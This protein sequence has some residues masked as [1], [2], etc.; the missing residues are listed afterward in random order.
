MAKFGAW[1]QKREFWYQL[2]RG[3]ATYTD[4]DLLFYYNNI[5]PVLR[6]ICAKWRISDPF[7]PEW[8][9]DES[10][11]YE[12]APRRRVSLPTGYTSEQAAALWDSAPVE[13]VCGSRRGTFTERFK[14]KREL[15][16]KTPRKKSAPQDPRLLPLRID[17]TRPQRELIQLVLESVRRHRETLLWERSNCLTKKRTRRRLD[18]YEAYLSTWDLRQRGMSF[19]QIAEQLYPEQYPHHPVRKNPINQRVQDH[20]RRAKFLIQVGYKE[21]A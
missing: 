8:K 7:S 4:R 5:W 11:S 16:E 10:G 12:H 2:Q 1:F 21:L 3:R 15:R 20:F 19:P 14:L 13:L 17:V 9:F 18:Q 6:E